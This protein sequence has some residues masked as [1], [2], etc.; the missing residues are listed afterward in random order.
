MLS[1]CKGLQALSSQL[2]IT[3]PEAKNMNELWGGAERWRGPAGMKIHNP[4]CHE[5][6]GPKKVDKQMA[7]PKAAGGGTVADSRVV[8]GMAEKNAPSAQKKTF[9]RRWPRPHSTRDV[10]FSCPA[11]RGLAPHMRKAW[12]LKRRVGWKGW[13]SNTAKPPQ[14][15]FGGAF[16]GGNRGTRQASQT[17]KVTH[18]YGSTT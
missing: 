17:E 11:F 4:P 2:S 6:P 1:A 18:H 14:S 10:L 12:Q 13:R 15:V 7:T 8:P 9:N 3:F 16:L 5:I